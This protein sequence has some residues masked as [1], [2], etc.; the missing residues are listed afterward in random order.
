MVS[1]HQ[2]LAFSAMALAIIVIPGP[3]VLFVVGRALAHGRRTALAGVVGG[4][5]AA[6]VLTVAVAVGVGSIVE[7]SAVVFT[8]LK[9]VGAVYIVYLGVQAIRHRRSLPEAV[10]RDE[11]SRGGRALV[12][13]FVVGITNPKTTV[14]FAAVLPQFVVREHGHAALQMMVFG[15]IFAV[16]ALLCD[17]VWGIA[18]GTARAWFARSPRRL[19]AIGGT[20]GLMMI[21][22]GVTVAATGRKE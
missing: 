2:L 13:G 19:A 16:I 11:E 12:Q 22:L 10:G 5:L 20:G 4:V 21:G 15:L 17:S 6:L 1:T 8:V 14:F 18:A 9:T 7:R 3:S